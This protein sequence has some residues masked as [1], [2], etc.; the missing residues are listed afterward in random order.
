LPVE[1]TARGKGKAHCSEE[2]FISHTRPLWT[3]RRNGAEC[4]AE[5]TA[6]REDTSLNEQ[7]EVKYN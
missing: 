5:E 4:S 6:K 1:R 2:Q 7:I 3:D